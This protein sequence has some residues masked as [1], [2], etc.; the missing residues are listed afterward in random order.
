MATGAKREG[1]ASLDGRIIE[2]GPGRDGRPGGHGASIVVAAFRFVE[3]VSAAPII[4]I[5]NG[6]DDP[7]PL[8]LHPFH[9][10]VNG[11]DV[12]ETGHDL[13]I[14]GEGN[15]KTPMGIGRHDQGLFIAEGETAHRIEVIPEPPI[16][17][18]AEDAAEGF[19]DLIRRRQHPKSRRMRDHL[20]DQLVHQAAVS[21][22]HHQGHVSTIYN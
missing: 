9:E 20:T 21:Q 14:I 6:T 19:P 11:H 22:F 7:K 1:E 3:G 4:A 2:A 13:G 5:P 17:V 10:E 15:A 8:L 18:E 16:P 12:F